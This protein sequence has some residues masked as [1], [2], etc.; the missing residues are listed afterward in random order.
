M[1]LADATTTNY[2]WIKP[3]VGASSD[4]WG[5][6]LNADLDSIDAALRAAMPAGFIG[7]W[8]GAATAIPG[9]W[10]I[11]DGTNGTPDLRDRFIVGAGLD[12]GVGATGGSV[13]QSITVNGHALAWSEMPA[14]NHGVND[15]GHTHSVYDPGHAHGISDPGHSHSLNDPGHAHHVVSIVD[16]DGP[17]SNSH[18]FGNNIG[19]LQ[20]ETLQTDTQ[21]TGVSLNGAATGVVINASGTGIGLYG[22]GTGVSTANAGG[23][24]AHSHTASASDNRPPYYAL[25]FIMK[26]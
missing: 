9:G 17:L 23:G 25:C 20:I 8:S 14:H 22:A 16:N 4:S 18:S 3:E 12:Y 5:S 1:R 11:C 10:L 21:G 13:G 19:N 15:P 26:T 2:G 6:K 7:L 24:A